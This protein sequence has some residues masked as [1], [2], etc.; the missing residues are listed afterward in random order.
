MSK[1]FEET[2]DATIF[3]SGTARSNRIL[4]KYERTTL[5]GVRMEQ[6]S[7]GAASALSAD[8]LSTKRTI[9]EI[10]EEEL[11]TRCIPLKLMRTLSDGSTEELTPS[12]MRILTA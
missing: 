5:I 9:R 4:T 3:D 1:A 7:F 10:A 2:S 11:R 6:L 12:Q 8:V